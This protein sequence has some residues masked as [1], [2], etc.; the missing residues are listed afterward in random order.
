MKQ[1]LDSFLASSHQFSQ[2][3]ANN[4]FQFDSIK[5]EALDDG[6][7]VTVSLPLITDS[8]RR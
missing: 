7:K 8:K 1:M 3:E 6:T 5:L 2:Q 4:F